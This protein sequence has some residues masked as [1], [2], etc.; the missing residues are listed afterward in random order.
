MFKFSVSFDDVSVSAPATV[1]KSTPAQR[2]SAPVAC[3]IGDALRELFALMHV[4]ATVESDI[5]ERCFALLSVHALDKK[6]HETFGAAFR[7]GYVAD[8][9]ARGR[10]SDKATK[11]S[12]VAWQRCRDY[13]VESG[14]IDPNGTTTIDGKATPATPA[15][16]TPRAPATAKTA[17]QRA[18]AKKKAADKA[19]AD[20]LVQGG[21]DL[22]NALTGA[23]TPATS[24][25]TGN[26]KLQ[27]AKA[28]TEAELLASVRELVNASDLKGSEFAAAL[29]WVAKSGANM[30]MFVEWFKSN[31]LAPS[32]PIIA[33]VKTKKAA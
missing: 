7:E 26:G 33:S 4:Q 25:A 20:K 1:A 16:K 2:K 8:A 18:A 28:A 19:A 12:F 24:N 5:R 3:S 29:N 27:V 14:W 31:A 9:V 10:D 30:G 21:K 17:R 6:A 22:A 23:P 32:S 15:G 13:A 11:A